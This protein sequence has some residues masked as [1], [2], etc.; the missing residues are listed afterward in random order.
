MSKEE[1]ERLYN[2]LEYN[3]STRN[4]LL[5]FSFTT[6]L[7]VLGVAIGTE[8]TDFSVYMYLI[9]FCL[10]LPFTAR[11]VY[12]RIIYAHISSFLMTYA[13]EKM[14][15]DIGTK[16]VPEKQSTFFSVMAFLVNYEMAILA[17]TCAVIFYCKY[18]STAQG[19]Y[20]KDLF[21]WLLPLLLVGI[22]V[23]IIAFGY[24]YT[25][26]QKNYQKKWEQFLKS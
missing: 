6:V 1:Y 24:N 17:S 18:F 3:L 19:F 4:N 2:R 15:F 20:A 16:K 10:I 12:Y 25:K 23:A 26:H 13:P 5:T 9:P 21:V 11:I 14:K 8:S 7:A 22:V